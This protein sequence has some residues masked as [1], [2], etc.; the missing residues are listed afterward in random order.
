MESMRLVQHNQSLEELFKLNLNWRLDV[1]PDG[2]FIQILNQDNVL[3]AGVNKDYPK[4]A[5]LLLTAPRL[6]DALSQCVIVLSNPEM[7]PQSGQM[8]IDYAA[9]VL[10]QSVGDIH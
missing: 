2:Q 4:V 10:K 8:T 1:A 3:V 9:S 5:H 6:V 7:Y